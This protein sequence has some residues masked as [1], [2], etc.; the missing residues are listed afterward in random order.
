MG[1]MVGLACESDTAKLKFANREGK[2]GTAEV[3]RRGVSNF[4]RLIRLFQQ[5]P[6]SAAIEECQ[7]AEAI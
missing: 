6:H 4:S 3:D 1:A 2:I 7:V 5:Q